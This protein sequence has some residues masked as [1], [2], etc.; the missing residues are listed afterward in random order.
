MA[1]YEGYDPNYGPYGGYPLGTFQGGPDPNVPGYLGGRNAVVQAILAQQ[2]FGDPGTAGRQAGDTSDVSVAGLFSGSTPG[3]GEGAP[4]PG[5]GIGRDAGPAPGGALGGMTTANAA[6]STAGSGELGPLGTN[7]AVGQVNPFSEGAATG[8]FGFGDTQNSP[9]GGRGGGKEGFGEAISQNT[10]SPTMPGGYTPDFGRATPNS[11]IAITG[12]R[13]TGPVD[14]FAGGKNDF[15]GAPPS[16]ALPSPGIYDPTPSWGSPTP[17]ATPQ[18]GPTMVGTVHPSGYTQPSGRGVPGEPGDPSDPGDPGQGWGGGGPVSG[19]GFGGFG[20][21]GGGAATG[22]FEGSAS[23]SN[24]GGAQGFSPGGGGYGD[25]SAAS[26]G[27]GGYS[28]GAFDAGFAAGAQA[29]ADAMGGGPGGGAGDTSG[30]S[31]G[32]GAAAGGND[33]GGGDPGGGGVG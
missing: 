28:A 2:G 13:S 19:G 30:S 18:P 16:G 9:F 4:G 21:F 20:A 7:N 3:Y 6:M 31:G 33:P 17:T 27:T 11:D 15:F 25:F 29:A 24:T 32:G 26:P 22:G 12:N 14:V 1:L 10:T 23:M 8:R 5:M